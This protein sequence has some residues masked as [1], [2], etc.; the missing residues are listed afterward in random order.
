M[1]M[2]LSAMRILIFPAVA[3]VR[4]SQY[5]RRAVSHTLCKISSRSC[6]Q[7]HPQNKKGSPPEGR[8]ALPAVPPRLARPKTGL[9]RED[10]SLLGRPGSR[11]RIAFPGA[12][13]VDSAWR[14]RRFAAM[15]TLCRRST[16]TARSLALSALV[17]LNITHELRRCKHWAAILTIFTYPENE[18]RPARAHRDREGELSPSSL[19]C[20]AECVAGPPLLQR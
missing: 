6:T 20:R 2:R 16:C 7:K 10:I 8:A 14:R 17:L 19:L 4:R 12:S 5:A 15:P 1:S 3:G 11:P 13:R 9:T 18:Q